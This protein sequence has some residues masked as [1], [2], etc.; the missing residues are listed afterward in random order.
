MLYHHTR[1]VEQTPKFKWWIAVLKFE[2]KNL[3]LLRLFV[4]VFGYE[5]VFRGGCMGLLPIVLHYNYS[6]GMHPLPVMKWVLLWV[7]WAWAATILYSYYRVQRAEWQRIAA[8][9]AAWHGDRKRGGQADQ[10]QYH[11]HP[12]D[13]SIV[14]LLACQEKWRITFWNPVNKV[15]IDL[16]QH[17]ICFAVWHWFWQ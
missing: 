13:P 8:A 15:C 10:P 7:D 14:R 3:Q 6:A 2:H 11:R 5:H 12:S 9:L 4:F 16:I 1:Q 17:V